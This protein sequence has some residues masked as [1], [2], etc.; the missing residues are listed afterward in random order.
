[1]TCRVWVRWAKSIVQQDGIAMVNNNQVSLGSFAAWY[2]KRE[3]AKPGRDPAPATEEEATQILETAHPGKW[4]DWFPHAQWSIALLAQSDF[5]Q[6]VF[7]E[8]SWTKR[9][10]LTVDDGPD[11][12][13]L[14]RVA[15]KAIDSSYLRTTSDPRHRVYYRQLVDGYRLRGRNRIAVCT[16]ENEK[17]R[18]PS[19][20]YY[21]L[22][23]A[24][25]S[26]PYMIL[27]LERRLAYEPVEA[28]V[29]TK[30]GRR[31]DSRELR[32]NCR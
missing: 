23:G 16:A 21:L 14:Q 8:N 20:R 29:A 32:A 18:N 19:G 3:S 15:T 10:G 11:Y 13:L 22:D 27:I 1:M 24:G 9:E 25:R 5:E 30:V 7:L 31:R 4:R 26:L 6:L 17:V 28:F 12:R 2:L